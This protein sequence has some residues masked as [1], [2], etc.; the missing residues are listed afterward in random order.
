MAVLMIFRATDK[1]SQ[2]VILFQLAAAVMA[3]PILV[4]QYQSWYWLAIFGW[5]VYLLHF[6]HHAGL[7][8]YFAHGSYKLNKFWHIFL[9][10][11][12]CLVTFGS[13]VGYSIAHRTHHKYSDHDGD[14][15]DPKNGKFNTMFFRWDMSKANLLF[16]NGMKDPWIRFAHDY[17]MLIVGV[18]Y[19][20]LLAIDYR[21]ALTYNVGV[22]LSFI[23]VGYVNIWCHLGHRFTYRNFETNDNSKN[24][25]FAGIL[26]GEWHNNHHKYPGRYDE[27]IKWWEFDLAARMI[28]LIKKKDA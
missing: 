1:N 8:R 15:H 24:D 25:I 5:F 2:N 13:P 19:L 16:A 12:S 10:L 20:T 17:Y 28:D 4:W 6:C 3:L 22:A 27:Q 21:L 14:P 11:S 23:A 26:G 9:T 18:F 7:H